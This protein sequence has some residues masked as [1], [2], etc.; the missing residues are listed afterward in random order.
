ME[1]DE[2]SGER[3]SLPRMFAALYKRGFTGRLEISDATE[4][5]TIFFRKGRVV[6]AQR[7]DTL[8]TLEN[9]LTQERLVT[10]RAYSD[11]NRLPNQSEEEIA[12]TLVRAGAAKKEIIQAGL[13]QQIRR[14]LLRI[15]Y[16]VPV[17]MDA[18]AA[19]HPF[20]GKEAPLGAELDAR[21]LIFPGIRAAYD[22]H[23]LAREL[24]HIAG[25]RVRVMS[26]SPMFLREAGFP[27]GS[28]PTLA[29]LTGNGVEISET[30]L[31][32]PTDRKKSPAKAIVLALHCLDLL[33]VNRQAASAG[34]AP[35]PPRKRTGVTG[36]NALDPATILQMAESFFK[37]GDTPRSERAFAIL[38]KS[39]AHNRRA[40]AFMA[41]INYWK[42]GTN[43][44]AAMGETTRAV[45]D[46]IRADPKFAYGHYFYGS[47]LKINNDLETA[48]RAFKA[49]LDLDP[50]FTDA[51]RELRLLTMRKSKP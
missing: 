49:A 37:N 50:A 11:A 15:F 7:P 46:S 44:A 6:K 39:D 16:A 41:W 32:T 14:Q 36:L 2:E 47:L 45:R 3:S 20:R 12:A 43:R 27:E 31:R 30:W 38:L 23:R 22:D 1:R 48:A 4:K 17:R 5:S 35:A 19:E 34:E 33:D 21:M 29:E 40:L 25:A 8:D 10:P 28:D 9:V 18:V 13:V 42:P 24:A 51:Q 26:V